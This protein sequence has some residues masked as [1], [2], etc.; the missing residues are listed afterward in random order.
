MSNSLYPISPR[1]RSREPVGAPVSLPPPLPQAPS[2]KTEPAGLRVLLRLPNV[3]AA[4]SASSVPRFRFADRL[5]ST[6]RRKYAALSLVVFIVCVTAMLLRGRRTSRPQ[7]EAAEAPRWNAAV[8]SPQAGSTSSPQ[9]GP[10]PKGDGAARGF[11]ASR[12]AGVPSDAA[13]PRDEGPVPW[14]PA[15]TP[16]GDSAYRPAVDAG[17]NNRS[18]AAATTPVPANPNP[19][20]SRP[21]TVDSVP[22]MASRYPGREDAADRTATTRSLPPTWPAAPSDPPRDFRTAQRPSGPIGG[23]YG[24]AAPSGPSPSAMLPHAI[25]QPAPAV[26]DTSGVGPSIFTRGADPSGQA[27]FMNRIDAPPIQPEYG[28]GGMPSSR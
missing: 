3:A 9:A 8:A 18:F 20:A 1:L 5:F 15:P 19:N 27:R 6:L 28:P 24:G 23:Q 12:G 22:N 10:L 14:H 17:A 25:Q 11:A 13:Q 26:P 2:P 4:S 16:S 21:S 7:E